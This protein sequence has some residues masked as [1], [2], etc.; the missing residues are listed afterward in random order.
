MSHVQQRIVTAYKE[1]VCLNFRTKKQD[2][3]EANTKLPAVMGARKNMNSVRL[4]FMIVDNHECSRRIS[5][6]K[7]VNIKLFKL[8]WLPSSQ[9]D[10][11]TLTLNRKNSENTLLNAYAAEARW[12]HERNSHDLS[13]RESNFNTPRRRL[14]PDS[15]STHT[16]L[17]LDSHSTHTRVNLILYLYPILSLLYSTAI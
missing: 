1:E 4:S 3:M 2:L 17:T 7:Y 15:N 5:S 12:R 13:V 10:P 6:L 9:S 11:D 16:R 14:T 8:L